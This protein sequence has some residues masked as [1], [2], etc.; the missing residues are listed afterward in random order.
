MNDCESST[1]VFIRAVP[2]P[3]IRRRKALQLVEKHLAH[4]MHV[5]KCDG[6]LEEVSG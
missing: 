5:T 4:N 2:I 6:D 3:C 1:C